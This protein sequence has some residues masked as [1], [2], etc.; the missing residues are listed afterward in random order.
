MNLN[1]VCWFSP[2][3]PIDTS[4][5]RLQDAPQLIATRPNSPSSTI[6]GNATYTDLT[7]LHKPLPISPVQKCLADALKP[8]SMCGATQGIIDMWD[9]LLKDH[10][11]AVG[12]CLHATDY[13]IVGAVSPYLTLNPTFPGAWFITKP[14]LAG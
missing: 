13:A 2:Q 1:P 5:N 6:S 8:M 10:T 9:R 14:G 3:S 4:V 11:K 12:N 7:P